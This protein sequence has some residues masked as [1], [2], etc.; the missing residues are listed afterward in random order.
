MLCGR[1]HRGREDLTMVVASC[2]ATVGLYCRLAA[3][4]RIRYRACLLVGR[5]FDDACIFI[6]DV[7]V[8]QPAIAHGSGSGTPRTWPG[9]E[10]L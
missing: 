2:H 9:G 7:D 10:L 4:D 6:N 8:A 1:M 3:D 5:R